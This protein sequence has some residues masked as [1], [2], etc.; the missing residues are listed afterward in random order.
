MSGV[1]T[2]G[3]FVEMRNLPLFDLN[4]R[5]D[6][7]HST[8]D[9][10]GNL[11]AD[12]RFTYSWDAENR[13]IAMET[14]ATVPVTA[15][16]K[17]AFAYDA[18]GRRIRKATWIGTSTGT[19]QPQL[20]LRF[21]HEPGGWNILAEVTAD[22]KF[23]RTYTWGTDLSGSLSR[24]G[25]VGGLLFTKIHP[26]NS[27]HANGMD[28]N[29]NITLLVSASA[30]QATATY[31]YGPF[32]EPIR[33]SG[34][35][36]KLNPYRFSSK[37]ADDETGLYDYGLRYYGALDGRW[38]SR[39]PIEENGGNNLYAFIENNCLDSWDM[40]GLS[41]FDREAMI[42][43][44]HTGSVTAHKATEK[45]FLEQIAKK[46][47]SVR[48]P[49]VDMGRPYR[50]SK[51]KEYGG[52]VCEKCSISSNG[53]FSVSYY[54]TQKMGDW[55]KGEGAS[56]S[57]YGSPPCEK[58]DRQVAW[59]HTHPSELKEDSTGTTKKSKKYRY[60]W[61]G[62]GSFSQ[63]DRDLV[64]TNRTLNPDALPIFV[65]YRSNIGSGKWKYSTDIY[66]NGE[67]VKYSE[68]MNPDWIDNNGQRLPYFK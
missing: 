35:Y 20:D 46:D 45:E 16:R 63:Y 58:G 53:E 38:R 26:D 22:G 36:S 32:G 15:R 56:I 61:T 42:K 12:G 34:E 14:L 66:P 19:W 55:P 18:V 21:L 29:G 62:A 7:G 54:L 10:D 57:P 41:V 31:D 24:S 60:Y 25:G 44:V 6:P 48:N 67:N 1:A 43:A 51:P 2:E 23:L 37:Y 30:G 59:W 40:L 28:L 33:E 49:Y 27:V 52:K 68:E 64:L 5:T 50:P 13:L 4:P 11:T 47:P 17:L 3:H 8:Y 39:D 65:T 9:Y